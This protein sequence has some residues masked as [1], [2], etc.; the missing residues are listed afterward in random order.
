M[1]KKIILNKYFLSCVGIAFFFL[2]WIVIYYIAGQS[3]YV[4]PS[5]SDTIKQVGI[6]LGDSF[7][8][9]CILESLKRMLIGFSIA[10]VLGIGVGIIVGN[11]FSLKYVFNPTMIAIKSVPTAALAFLFL[12]LIGYS[13]APIFIVGIIV[14]PIVYE[15]TV[16]GY[17]TI[18]PYVLMSARVDGAKRIRSNIFIRFPLALPTIAIGLI[19]SFALSFKIEIMAEVIAS[20]SKSIGLGRAIQTSFS[21]STNGLVPTFA[22]SLIAIIIMLLVTLLFDGLK[23][24]FKLKA[25]ASAQA[26]F[27]T[28]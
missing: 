3:Q 13:E 14:F 18:D 4:F 23:K 28:F 22:Y 12:T 7:T 2:V 17:R 16:A 9:Q 11:Y 21:N 8:Y 6:Y 15:A 24:L 5:P 10:S 25:W 1:I 20:T 26:C 19:S 27:F